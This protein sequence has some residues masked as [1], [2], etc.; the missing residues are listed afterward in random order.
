M[1]KF[2][3]V[4]LDSQGRPVPGAVIAVQ[5]YPGGSPATVYETDAVGAA[6]VPTT[7]AFGAFFFYAPNGRYNYTVTV[8]GVLRKTVTD[9][10]IVDTVYIAQTSG[11][12]TPTDDSGGPGVLSVASGEYVKTGQMVFIAGRFRFGTTGDSTAALLG[13]LPFAAKSGTQSYAIGCAIQGNTFGA[14]V[15]STNLGALMFS[16]APGTTQL[17]PRWGDIPGLVC[18]NGQLDIATIE[19]SGWYLTDA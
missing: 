1:Q 7:D 10:E 15:S 3:D 8:G 17:T 4:V 18:S 16:I 6:Y 13:G 14:T 2:Q 9:V 12:W 5:S 11:V 19:F